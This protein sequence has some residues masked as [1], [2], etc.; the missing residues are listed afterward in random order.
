MI[1]PF[2]AVFPLDPL[3]VVTPIIIIACVLIQ[4]FSPEQTL[5]QRIYKYCQSEKAELTVDYVE[6][7]LEGIEDFK[8]DPRLLCPDAT[9]IALGLSTDKLEEKYNIEPSYIKDLEKHKVQLK[10]ELSI[11]SL[12]TFDPSEPSLLSLFSAIF[13]H[14][15][16][17]HL[18]GN[19]LFLWIFGAV[20]E[21][22]LGAFKFS[23]LFLF[24][25]VVAHI[26]YALMS[27][28]NLIEGLPTLGASA[29]VYGVLA[30]IFVMYPSLKV[31]FVYFFFTFIRVLQ[32]PAKFLIGFYVF[33][34]ILRLPMMKHY[35]VN[36]IGHLTGFVSVYLLL[37]YVLGK[38]SGG[39][40]KKDTC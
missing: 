5:R 4:F 19:M 39:L 9:A 40:L 17:M 15:G 25:G 11:S 29:A 22:L 31:D 32:L 38:K 14:A 37:K 21:S 30:G 34:D 10:K 18:I 28:L 12:R 27:W 24:S 2:R 13:Y 16:W 26:V 8:E 23:F 1:I 35:G 36:F 7:L 33:F 20:L 6:A 3:P